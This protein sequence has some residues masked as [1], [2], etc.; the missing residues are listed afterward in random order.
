MFLNPTTLQLLSIMSGGATDDSTR[1]A[2]KRAEKARDAERIERKR[3]TPIMVAVKARQSPEQLRAVIAQNPTLLNARDYKSRTAIYIAANNGNH[4]LVSELYRAGAVLHDPSWRGGVGAIHMLASSGATEL[5]REILDGMSRSDALSCIKTITHEGRDVLEHCMQKDSWDVP[6]LIEL[7]VGYGYDANTRFAGGLTLLMYACL[8]GKAHTASGL[9]RLGA[10][11]SA[12][13]KDG[14]TPLL[15]ATVNRYPEIVRMLVAAGADPT[16]GKSETHTPIAKSRR[17]AAKSTAVSADRIILRILEGAIARND[18][19][20]AVDDGY[21]TE[22]APADNRDDAA[23][24]PGDNGEREVH[25][26]D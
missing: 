20:A 15:L 17:M 8:K 13:K 7:A 3:Y 12:V 25:S 18:A 2:D 24:T 1:V 22:D 16:S 26:L 21:N 6:S 14:Y 11:A 19:R 5:L 4:E 9:L 10:D 23:D